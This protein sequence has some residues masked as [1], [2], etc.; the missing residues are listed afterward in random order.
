MN[1]KEILKNKLSENIDDESEYAVVHIDG[2]IN[3]TVAVML[4]KESIKK[5]KILG[6]LTPKGYEDE[7]FNKLVEYLDI[8]TIKINI[9][10]ICGFTD[11]ECSKAGI[12]PNSK[13]EDKYINILSNMICYIV[14]NSIDDG[15]FINTNDFTRN[16]VD[17]DFSKLI[18]SFSDYKL[19]NGIKYT[20]IV[21]LAKELNIP[22]EFIYD[23][24][25]KN[26]EEKYETSLTEEDE[27]IDIDD[28]YI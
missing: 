13:I 17:E 23:P 26:D 15:L 25:T 27:D 12:N 28:E 22:D 10:N 11:L 6:I 19:F 14:S 20:S 3:S 7:Y 18:S 4:L 2:R 1:L 21:E 5:E 24:I 8:K 9:Q 16:Y